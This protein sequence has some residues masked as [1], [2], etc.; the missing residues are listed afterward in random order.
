LPL[1]L[2]FVETE[3]SGPAVDCRKPA[4]AHR[5]TDTCYSEAVLAHLVSRQVLDALSLPLW[6]FS[7]IE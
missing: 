6:T 5:L 2:R 1:L 4:T 3:Q 7:A